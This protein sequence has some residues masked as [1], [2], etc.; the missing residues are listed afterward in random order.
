MR[1]L[2][3][4]AIC[5][6]SRIGASPVYATRVLT[7][8]IAAISDDEVSS[9]DGVDEVPA[10]PTPVKAIKAPV[11]AV[12][13]DDEDDDESEPDEYRVEKI[14]KHDFS[15]D[16]VVLYQIKWEGYEKKADL[17]WEPIENLYAPH[18]VP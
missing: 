11:E 8:S 17:T 9:D 5:L 18:N 3:R 16:N 15:E 12:D 1:P 4:A 2:Q 7:H 10:K 6:V 13:E 14:L